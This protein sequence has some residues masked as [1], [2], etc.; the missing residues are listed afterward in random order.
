MKYRLKKSSKSRKKKNLVEE[1]FW[2]Q[3]NR[4]HNKPINLS[5]GTVEIKVNEKKD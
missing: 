4:V 1:D 3:F 2:F 5:M